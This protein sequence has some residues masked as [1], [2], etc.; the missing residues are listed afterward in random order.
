MPRFHIGVETTMTSASMKCSISRSIS[1]QDS[2]WFLSMG[3]PIMSVYLT[4]MLVPAMAGR[5]WL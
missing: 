2:S 5:S 1:R 4:S 3:R